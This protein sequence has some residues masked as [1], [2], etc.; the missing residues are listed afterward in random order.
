M[1]IKIIVLL[2]MAAV[3]V[4]LF[5]A[6]ASLSRGAAGDSQKT[7]R[8][9]TWRLGISI[10]I[11]VGL[12]VASHFGLIAPHGLTKAQPQQAPTATPEAR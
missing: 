7:L 2:A 9:L 4:S 5:M 6:L 1:W 3:L 12:A 11:V 8:R 10:A